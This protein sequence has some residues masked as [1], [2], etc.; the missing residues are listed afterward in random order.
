[1]KLEKLKTINEAIEDIAVSKEDYGT[2]GFVMADAI[3]T[4]KKNRER[5]DA[6]MHE[7]IKELPNEDRFAHTKDKGTPEM[8]KMHLSEDAFQTIDLRNRGNRKA[9]RE[10]SGDNKLVKFMKD[11]YADLTNKGEGTWYHKLGN[12]LYYVMAAA[13]DPNNYDAEDVELF[14]TSKDGY[15]I[16]GKIAV[17]ID[18]LQSD[19]DFDWFMPYEEGGDVWNTESEFYKEE[20]FSKK[21]QE[22]VSEYEKMKDLEI[23][24][25]GRIIK[26][27]K[28]QESLGENVNDLSLTLDT[29]EKALDNTNYPYQLSNNMFLIE[30]YDGRDTYYEDI[31]FVIS[32][33]NDGKILLTYTE[34]DYIDNVIKQDKS[35]VSKYVKL[36]NMKENEWSEKDFVD[37]RD[38]ILYYAIDNCVHNPI[39]FQECPSTSYYNSLEVFMDEKPEGLFQE[40]L[41]LKRGTKNESFLNETGEVDSKKCADILNNW[42]DWTEVDETGD[43]DFA[44]D[45]LRSLASEKQITEEEYDFIMSN[46]DDLLKEGLSCSNK[47]KKLEEGMKFGQSSYEDAVKVVIDYYRDHSAED[48]LESIFNEFQ[49]INEDEAYKLV[50]SLAERVEE[51]VGEDL[52]DSQK[53]PIKSPFEKKEGKGGLKAVQKYPVE[54]PMKKK[55]SQFVKAEQKAP[56][57]ESLNESVKIISDL[58]DF[59]PWSGAVNTWYKIIDAGKLDTLDF[60]L[61]DMYPEGI[62]DV[63]LN[64]LLWHDSEWVLEMVG[65]SEEQDDEEQDEDG[66]EDVEESLDKNKMGKGS[67]YDIDVSPE[68][69]DKLAESLVNTINSLENN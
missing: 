66:I 43:V 13:G 4:S 9:L 45:Q 31:I 6:V 35:A 52:E 20:D 2:M 68:E 57:G 23:D 59:K 63:G 39:K 5:A 12:N 40:S 42:I 56:I 28:V 11:A 10:A 16:I 54:S 58:S 36:A 8:K 14:A 15:I 30:S 67:E 21:A 37:Y 32:V 17:N 51:F 55:D 61:E 48:A 33:L 38:S 24:E 47:D 7:K 62:S 69:A 65:I 1:M 53:Y 22:I 19:Y 41:S 29:I 3:R 44:I 64:D 60:M 34:A 27:E 25:E 49:M 46:W 18:D 50:Y 26:S